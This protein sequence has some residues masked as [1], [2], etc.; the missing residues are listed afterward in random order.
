MNFKLSF[1]NK[2]PGP[3]LNTYA[4]NVWTHHKTLR[5]SCKIVW[6]EK[7]KK[8]WFSQGYPVVLLP[9]WSA[10]MP[11][12]EI[13]CLFHFF[14]YFYSFILVLFLYF[15]LLLWITLL[16]WN[17]VITAFK[18]VF[19]LWLLS[20]VKNETLIC[21]KMML[22]WHFEPYW[23]RENAADIK[24]LVLHYVKWLSFPL[25]KEQRFRL[26]MPKVMAL[27]SEREIAAHN[28]IWLTHPNH[29]K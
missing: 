15:F 16:F 27:T 10:I 4:S 24:F 21:F 12:F 5:K 2:C 14:T 18:V 22:P 19:C 7:I 28:S 17:M 23:K 20:V 11:F 29:L 1:V 26:T 3:N 8:K 13:L 6:S 9:F 25:E